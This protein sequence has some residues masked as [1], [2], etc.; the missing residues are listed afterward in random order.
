MTFDELLTLFEDNKVPYKLIEILTGPKEEVYVINIYLP[1]WHENPIKHC[2]PY[3]PKQEYEF[4]GKEKLIH[5]LVN[6]GIP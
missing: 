2:I 5:V 6:Q 4:E 3:K 1:N